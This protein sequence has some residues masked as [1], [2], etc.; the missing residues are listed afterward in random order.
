MF[1]KLTLLL[2]TLKVTGISSRQLQRFFSGGKSPILEICLI[3]LSMARER[4][5]SA[6]FKSATS[7]FAF[8]ESPVGQPLLRPAKRQAC[9]SATQC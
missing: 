2:I 4:A 8:S 5:S 7:K 1:L 9:A 3:K 6:A